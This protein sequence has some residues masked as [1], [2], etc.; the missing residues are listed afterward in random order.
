MD[1]AGGGLED[2]KEEGGGDVSFSFVRSVGS[3]RA[4]RQAGRQAAKNTHCGRDSQGSSVDLGMRYW[5]WQA[6]GRS[7]REISK[8]TTGRANSPPQRGSR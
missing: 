1:V 4:G 2:I 3:W 7:S 8:T 6:G 5:R